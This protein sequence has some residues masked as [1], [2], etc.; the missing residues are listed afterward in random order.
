MKFIIA[1]FFIT[2]LAASFSVKA[3]KYDDCVLDNM[4]GVTSD[5]AAKAI[6][7]A[8]YSKYKKKETSNNKSYYYKDECTRKKTFLYDIGTGSWDDDYYNSY[9]VTMTNNSSFRVWA[10]FLYRKTSSSSNSFIRT[11][12]TEWIEPNSTGV[13][14][15]PEKEII[16]AS[17][18]FSYKFDVEYDDC[19]RVK[20]EY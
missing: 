19:K 2:I 1:L 17:E 3:S 14:R 16:F 9:V 4:K 15:I 13:F 5:A 8:C 18:G 12:Y 7:Q 20:V 11:N 10:R 6:M